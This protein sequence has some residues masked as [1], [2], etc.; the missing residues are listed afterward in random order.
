MG[1]SECS[2]NYMV[3]KKTHPYLALCLGVYPGADGGA[4]WGGEDSPHP[5]LHSHC[6]PEGG[7]GSPLGHTHRSCPSLNRS[8]QT[9]C[10]ITSCQDRLHQNSEARGNM[11]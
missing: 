4:H 5:C 3:S 6:L 7:P 9:C 11:A 1:G 2:W 10:A 8:T